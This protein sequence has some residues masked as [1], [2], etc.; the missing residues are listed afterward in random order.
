M[1]MAFLI[2]PLAPV[3]ALALSTVP[4]LCFLATTRGGG[5]GGLTTIMGIGW[6]WMLVCW[7]DSDA[8][9][10]RRLP[11]F[12]FGLLVGIYLPLSVVWYCLWSRGWRGLLLLLL[13]FG[14]WLT[15]FIIAMIFAIIRALVA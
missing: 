4:V 9:R 10:L 1:P 12:D 2:H 14:L 7:M 3:V 8:R 15:P 6:A 11:C 5:P 13:L